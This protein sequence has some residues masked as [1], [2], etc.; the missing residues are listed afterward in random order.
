MCIIFNNSREYIVYHLEVS[1]KRLRELNVK[2][3]YN[4]T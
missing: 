3:L 4:L 2:N 1:P